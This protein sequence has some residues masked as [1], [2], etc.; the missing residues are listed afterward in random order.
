M[1]TQI[2]PSYADNYYLMTACLLRPR[3]TGNQH[4]VRQVLAS[5]R[6]TK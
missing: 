1:L 2:R 6:F 5:I 4:A 3:F